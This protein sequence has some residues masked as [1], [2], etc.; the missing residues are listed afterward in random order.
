MPDETL[1]QPLPLPRPRRNLTTTLLAAV[2]AFLVGGGIVAWLAQ[3]GQLPAS[4]REARTARMAPQPSAVPLAASAPVPQP[5]ALPTDPAS[6]GGVET[7]L[8]LLED[9]LTRI[10]SEATA[11]SGH[12]A[13]SE[14]LLVAYAAR[15][16][17]DK[18]EPLSF[19]ADQL[20]LRFGGAQPQAVQTIIAAAKRPITLDELIGQL[21]AVAPVLTGTQRDEST[22]TRIRREIASLFV[23]RRAPVPAATAESRIARARLMLARGKIG[24]AV[25]EVE[26]LPGA[27]GAQP[28]IGEARRYENTQRALDVIET[29]AMLEPRT[30]RD[31]AGKTVDQPSPLA[32]DAGAAVETAA[33]ATG[34]F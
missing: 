6:L 20:T 25:A 14:A 7:R 31:G 28:W 19:V 33:P 24:E 17:I 11:A 5:S 34:S 18:G 16:R 9:R 3:T 12:A 23:V 15:R 30:L 22:W 13:R 26:R 29:A 8:A 32:P 27:E 1:S 10:D 2:L 21:E 4:L